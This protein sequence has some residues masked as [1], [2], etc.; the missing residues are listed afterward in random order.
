M[1]ELLEIKNLEANLD[2]AARQLRAAIQNV[3]KL[4]ED[5]PWRERADDLDLLAEQIVDIRQQLLLLKLEVPE[6][7]EPGKPV[8]SPKTTDPVD[9][10]DLSKPEGAS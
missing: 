3:G 1:A 6:P 9:L 4:A 2:E 7:A 8:E 10:P 5:A